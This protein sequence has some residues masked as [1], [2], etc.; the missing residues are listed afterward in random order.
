[1]TALDSII[2]WA[3]SDLPEWQSDAVRRHSYLGYKSPCD[4][5]RMANIV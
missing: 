2:A 4:F 5:E 1:M 3:K